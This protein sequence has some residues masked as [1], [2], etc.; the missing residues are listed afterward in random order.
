MQI[1]LL[2]GADNGIASRMGLAILE[3]TTLGAS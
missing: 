2:W 3:D 1:K